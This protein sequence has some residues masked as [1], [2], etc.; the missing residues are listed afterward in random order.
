MKK[1]FSTLGI[2]IIIGIGYLLF[3]STST[4]HSASSIHGIAQWNNGSAA[5]QYV[6]QVPIPT[7][8]TFAGETVPLHKRDVREKLDRELTSISFKHSS[9]IRI[10]KLANRHLP[11]IEEILRNNGV[12]DDFKYLAVA[13]SGLEN[14]ISP[15]KA[16]GIWQFME[17]TAKSYGLEV[18]EDVEERYHLEKATVAACKYFKKAKNKF[19]SWTTAAASYNRGMN[20][21]NRQINN[22][23]SSDY[24]DLYLNSETARYIF[25][26]LAY[27]QFLNNPQQYGFYLNSSDLY[28]NIAH[29]TIVISSITNIANFAKSHQTNY[30][31]IKELNPWLKKTY[32]KA[33]AGKSYSVKIPL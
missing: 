25:R 16:K 11:K 10:L 30:K 23:A 4:N 27:K 9:T 12:P 15:K 31:Y 1:I 33:K 32:L 6:A 14:V 20:G 24:Y 13:E 28:P 21:M 29:K 18:S 3:L 5:T 2:G 19:G 7:S 22:Q 8:M 26:I 17:G